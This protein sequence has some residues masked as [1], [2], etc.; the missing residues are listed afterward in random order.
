MDVARDDMDLLAITE[1]GYGKRTLV[2]EYRKTN[3]GAKGVKTI[4]IT[5]SKGGLAGA[6]VV[7]EHEDLVFISRDGMVQRTAVRGINRYGRGAQGVK[8][9]NVRDD[10]IV[11]AV[12][13]VVSSDEE[14][15][16][17]EALPLDGAPADGEG[18]IA[19]DAPEAAAP[20]DGEAEADTPPAAPA[21]E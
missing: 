1:N 16:A 13:L 20:A 3:R 9:M 7:R 12:A 18:V 14:T 5:E 6:L 21:A 10:D 19:L 11:S 4:A 8:V 2:A 15:E 17:T